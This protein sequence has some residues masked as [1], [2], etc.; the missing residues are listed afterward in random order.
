MPFRPTKEE[1]LS[2]LKKRLETMPDV[3]EKV[4]IPT[5]SEKVEKVMMPTDMLPEIFSILD[6]EGVT[7]QDR[8]KYLNFARIIFK[9]KHR[10]SGRALADQ[11]ERELRGYLERRPELRIDIL[12]K[13]K[14][15]V[16]GLP[17]TP[18]AGAGAT[19]KGT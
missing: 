18:S 8:I 7:G 3:Y 16:L 1:R 13:I 11:A 19:P 2:K 15:K 4:G 6:D 10:Y 12:R 5:I 17:T 9:L 14:D